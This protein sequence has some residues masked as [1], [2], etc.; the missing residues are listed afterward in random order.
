MRPVIF[1][2]IGTT[3]GEIACSPRERSMEVWNV[4]TTGPSATHRA[5]MLSDGIIGSW[6][7][8][9]SKSPCSTQRRTRAAT[10]GPKFRRATD[11]L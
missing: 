8:R 10:T 4:A 6:M 5:S 9:R 7:C 2:S 1:S 3:S 11:P